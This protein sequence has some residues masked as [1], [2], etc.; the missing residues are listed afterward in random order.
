VPDSFLSSEKEKNCNLKSIKK[1]NA[2]YLKL[3]NWID[4]MYLDKLDGEIEEEFYKRH[5][6]QWREEQDRI[7][8]QIRHH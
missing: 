7:Q 1:L 3:Q 8:E 4:Q 5:V 6:S 2:Q